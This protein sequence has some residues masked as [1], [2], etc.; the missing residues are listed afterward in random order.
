MEPKDGDRMKVNPQLT[1]QANWI[2]GEVID[3]DH[4]PFMG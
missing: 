3:V 4:N 1:A 2:D